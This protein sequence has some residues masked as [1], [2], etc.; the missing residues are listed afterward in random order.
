MLMYYSNPVLVLTISQYV[1]LAVA[2]S[3]FAAN[4]QAHF[5]YARRRQV[6]S[7][8]TRYVVIRPSIVNSVQGYSEVE[9]SSDTRRK[10]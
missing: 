7:N 1:A 2:G 9:L 4:L 5:E 3:A 10:R 6:E 8:L